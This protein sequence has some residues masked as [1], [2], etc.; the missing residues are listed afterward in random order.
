MGHLGAVQGHGR[1]S[2]DWR[3]VFVCNRPCCPVEPNVV[4]SDAVFVPLRKRDMRGD[5]MRRGR[6]RARSI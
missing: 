1:M 6:I 4:T 3:K 5:T 2:F